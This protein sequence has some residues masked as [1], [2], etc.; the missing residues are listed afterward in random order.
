MKRHVLPLLAL[1]ALPAGLLAGCGGGSVA[2]SG[3]TTT[4]GTAAA[5]QPASTSSTSK[6]STTSR[7][8]ATGTT[9]H[10][11]ARV[12]RHA[13]AAAQITP[14]AASSLARTGQLV[15]PVATGGPGRV[16]AFAQAQIAGAGIV[17]VATARPVTATRAGIVRLTLVLTPLARRQLAAGRSVDAFVAIHFSRNDVIQREEIVLRP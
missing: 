2:G 11:P 9:R 15:L 6:T 3:S 7:S 1:L 5:T 10:A 13:F 12:S 14:P 4:G 17:H 16:S 8:A